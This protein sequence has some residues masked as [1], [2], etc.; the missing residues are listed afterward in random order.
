MRTSV[1]M[2]YVREGSYIP[3]ILISAAG[4][5]NPANLRVGDTISGAWVPGTYPDYGGNPVS[6]T[7]TYTVDGA[8]V[9]SNYVLQAG[10]LVSQVKVDLTATG[11][12]T[13]TYYS[14][15]ETVTD[16]S[17]TLLDLSYLVPT[18]A[19]A[20]SLTAPVDTATG[21]STG[22]GSVDTDQGN[23][24]LY[25]VATE[26]FNTPT[27]AQVKAGEDY[28][29]ATAAD[30]GFQA[31]SATGTQT[32][33]PGPTGL[34]VDTQY[35]LHFMHE[36]A[37]SAQSGVVSGDGFMTADITAPTLSSPVDTQN[38]ATAANGSV[39]TNETTGTLYWVVST[40]ST[41]P[42]KAQVK[43]GQ[44]HTGAAAAANGSQSVSASGTQ[45]LSP[46]PSGLTAATA[47]T[48]HYMHEDAAGNQSTVVSGDGFTTAS[49]SGITFLGSVID[50][51]LAGGSIV[52]DLTGLSLAQNDFIVGY[53]SQVDNTN[54]SADSIGV[55]AGSTGWTQ[56]TAQF[57]NDN[58]NVTGVFF[59]KRMGSS[60]DTSITLDVANAT[61]ELGY[62]EVRAYRGVDTTTAFDVATT[63]GTQAN[64]GTP[65]IVANTPSSAGSVGVNF[66]CGSDTSALDA[67][68]SAPT[69]WTNFS[70]KGHVNGAAYSGQLV[71]SDF[72]GWTSGA[73]GNAA[74][75]PG[76][77]GGSTEG[78]V[79]ATAILRAA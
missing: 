34:T 43:A 27:P 56:E 28:L 15:I 79:S 50:S 51:T 49:A 62:A 11:A 63:F 78:R 67:A 32:L 45:T 20:P 24:T 2:R 25:W 8:P 6:E 9:A 66:S 31:V 12:N 73:I 52:L 17:F 42:T 74:D 33:S 54:A 19:G 10:D 38:G 76:A 58:R 35:Y 26:T 68:T 3:P 18:G 7:L 70:Q 36:N 71:S 21:T 64:S 53:V 30:S 47:Y 55:N 65:Y 14:G 59:Y 29:G 60:P 16:F 41:A 44:M 57:A 23:G 72:F 37:A 75:Y 46:A 5:L 61:G 39:D 1:L 13:R 77:S 4:Y 22:A 40:S 48:I 69:G